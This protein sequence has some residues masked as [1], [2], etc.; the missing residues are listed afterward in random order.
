MLAVAG[1]ISETF[2]NSEKVTS[3]AV[4]GSIPSNAQGSAQ[5]HTAPALG[6]SIITAQTWRSYEQSDPTHA[7]SKHNMS[8]LCIGMH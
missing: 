4:D 7:H 8:L 2:P 1:S 6:T 3:Q 5:I